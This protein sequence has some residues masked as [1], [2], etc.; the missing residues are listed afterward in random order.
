MRLELRF[1]ATFRETVGQKTIE[2]E[3]EEGMTVGAVLESLVAEYPELDLFDEDGALRDYL[4]VMKNGENVIHLQGLATPLEDGDKVSL[5]P[6]VEG[7][8]QLPTAEA[9]SSRAIPR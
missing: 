1:F 4:N 9:E 8:R 7:G 5:F 3:F 2:R 6:P